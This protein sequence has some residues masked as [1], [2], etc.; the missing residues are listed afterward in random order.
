[1]PSENSHF[2]FPTNITVVPDTTLVIREDTT[3]FIGPD[4]VGSDINGNGTSTQPYGTLKKAW[5]RAGEMLIRGTAIL[6][7]RFQSGF[8][9]IT[10]PYTFFPNNL[11]HPNGDRI[12]IEGDPAHIK[13]HYLYLVENYNWDYSKYSHYG[14]TGNVRLFG[15]TGSGPGTTFHGFT[16]SDA[17]RVTDIG[18]YVAISNPALS[19]PFLY[20]DSQNG[21]YVGRYRTD[22]PPHDESSLFRR[23]VDSY[24]D[25]W[26]SHGLSHDHALGIVGLATII[27]ATANPHILS[28]SFKNSNRDPRVPSFTDS[29]SGKIRGNINAT[30]T[31]FGHSANLPPAQQ[32]SPNGYY[33]ANYASGTIDNKYT[34]YPSQYPANPS[35]NHITDDP[36]LLT[37][38]P[39]ILRINRNYTGNDTSTPVTP[40]IS[41][42]RVSGG[43]IKAIRNLMFV[44][45]MFD[46]AS[47]GAQNFSFGFSGVHMVNYTGER[48]TPPCFLL[49]GSEVG[50][51]HI[52]IQGF[53]DR[54]G[55]AIVLKNSKLSAYSD[56]I[57]YGNTIGNNVTDEHTQGGMSV[58]ARLGS[59]NNTPVLMINGIRRG[60][61]A[62]NS[63][64]SLTVGSATS[65]GDANTGISPLF[66]A[67]HS[68]DESVWVQTHAGP[69]LEATNSRCSIGSGIFLN[70]TQYPSFRLG[71]NLPRFSGL[72]LSTGNTTGI[73]SPQK[74]ESLDPWNYG[75][76]FNSVVMYANGVT[77]GRIVGA[78]YAGENNPGITFGGNAEFFPAGAGGAAAP[79]STINVFFYGVRFG[80]PSLINSNIDLNGYLTRNEK[81]ELVGFS[82]N[83]ETTRTSRLVIEGL[84]IGVTTDNGTTLQL[85]KI[86]QNSAL[87]GF[88]FLDVH[89]AKFSLNSNGTYDSTV[90]LNNST[91]TLHKNM[92][93]SGGACGVLATNNSKLQTHRFISS[94]GFP[95]SCI[96]GEFFTDSCLLAEHGSV[97]SV[98]SLFTRHPDILGLSG[99]VASVSSEGV[100]SVVNLDSTSILVGP[101]RANQGVNYWT[102]LAG[103]ASPVLR[104]E[105]VSPISATR[106]GTVS[107]GSVATP[108]SQYSPKVLILSDSAVYIGPTITEECR[109]T[110]LFQM[111]CGFG[112][113][114][115]P[116][117]ESVPT[118][119]IAANSSVEGRVRTIGWSGGNSQAYRLQVCQTDQSK[120]FYN[121]SSTGQMYR[122]WT[123]P[124]G[125]TSSTA[126]ANTVFYGL[127]VMISSVGTEYGASSTIATDAPSSNYSNFVVKPSI[128]S[129]RGYS[130]SF[131]FFGTNGKGGVFPYQ[132][133]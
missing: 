33:G 99:R 71:I 84:T 73:Y 88:S 38:Y 24:A 49:D 131:V 26:Y 6:Y 110:D 29:D 23:T 22:M 90:I 86:T 79:S 124:L 107:F 125:S 7:I 103:N 53:G 102:G 120:R 21:I 25:V 94:R 4:G 68:T 72:T 77:V 60:I 116:I 28:L 42:I 98:P 59:Q 3:I 101:T 111:Y 80:D 19:S 54:N 56:W 12:I 93:V 9:N 121:V 2:P 43:K 104:A 52:G 97:I 16:G 46:G 45:E 50:I 112:G 61:V 114:I 55:A 95:Y 127:P 66:S 32:Y 62:D 51:R 11:F 1:M 82:D 13:Q 67:Y 128:G 15:R 87:R 63:E 10:N 91:L 100:G 126:T 129:N 18:R 31:L 39:V 64:L 27:G 108:V 36:M 37:S 47:A 118:G 85:R 65:K 57:E 78:Y 119:S 14:H 76:S 81:I 96:M 117:P 105:N 113:R 40:G 92:I 20:N 41:P 44:D 69:P 48:N 74:W 70:K 5:E 75:P 130:G 89:G 34:V 35:V 133:Y 115:A 83:S 122:F 58:F 8:Y 123:H 132:V 106:S 17:T 109:D 30:F